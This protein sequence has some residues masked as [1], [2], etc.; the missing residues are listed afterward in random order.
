MPIYRYG[1]QRGR[2]YEL[3]MSDDYMVV[4]TRSRKSLYRDRPYETAAISPQSRR[5]LSRFERVT[6]FQV[7]GVEVLQ[8]KARDNAAAIRDEAREQLKTEEAVQFAGRVLV[9][10]RSHC[11][12]IYTENLF[13]K[14]QSRT[15]E[16]TCQEL[17]VRYGLSG[18]PID[19]ARNAYFLRA[20]EGTG[21][22]I[23]DLSEQLLNEGIV[24]LCHPEL[25]R[26]LNQRQVQGSDAQTGGVQA[27]AANG[28]GAKAFR[29]QW[30]LA[31][32][33][34]GETAIDASANVTAAWPLSQGNGITIAVID[35]GFDLEHEEFSSPGKIIA[36]RDATQDTNNPRPGR[37]DNHGTA[38][39]GV[40]CG[41]G[42]FGAAGVA[43]KAKLMPIRLASG[44]GSIAE[45]EAFA[46]AARQGADIISCSWGPPDGAWFDKDDPLH[47]RV[48][49][50][51]DSSRLAMEFALE[52]GRDGKGC[53]ICWAAGNG[54]ELADN[55]GYASFE[56]VI[57]VAACNDMNT[58]SAYSDFGES[59]WCAFP[60]NN[61]EPSLTSGIWTADR[62]GNGG[63]NWGNARLGD[64]AGNYT[65][66]FGGTSS[67]CPG[68]A[69]VA[70]LILARNPEL[71]WEQVKDVIKQSCD[72]IDEASGSYDEQ[73]HSRLYGYG[74]VNALKAVELAAPPTQT[75]PIVVNQAVRDVPIQD[76]RSAELSLIVAE[77]APLLNLEVAVDLDHT[78][79]GDLVVTLR[80]PESL[81]IEPIKLH[82][83]A[84]GGRNNLKQ[85]YDA[86]MVPELAQL[87]G[88][89]PTGTWTLE[90]LDL[91][92]WDNGVLHSFT[93]K[94][95][96]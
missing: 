78:Y 56:K 10:P 49:P 43:P 20:A 34:I 5:L 70:A 87:E 84:G 80:P 63:Y 50:L 25:I 79:I 93:L 1:G 4:R 23:F 88:K 26:H 9:E 82:N 13:I 51:P 61:G 6:Q 95:E 94:M 44:L 24:E 60:S 14:F 17:M 41:E 27:S 55:D 76:L 58:R 7:A 59:I 89:A 92:R 45:A 15:A 66:S 64:K 32:T 81:E 18:R 75:T 39:A 73:G 67:A 52:Q 68:V 86:I 11:P 19:F 91:A 83:R 12:T 96:V 40:A 47:Q 35:D 29:Q 71:R 90:V 85:T 42:R 30:H 53:V 36:P 62:S 33:T 69:G 57:A 48:V 77:T 2:A 37:R 22:E 3:E 21:T 74:R 38:C 8:T 31:S 72:R 46:W 16:A 65:N 54:N 28:G